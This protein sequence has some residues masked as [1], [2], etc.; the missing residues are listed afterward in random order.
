MYSVPWR[1]LLL[2]SYTMLLLRIGHW[3]RGW[4]S[5]YLSGVEGGLLNA[6]RTVRGAPRASLDFRYLNLFP[7]HSPKVLEIPCFLL[8]TPYFFILK[9]L[10]ERS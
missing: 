7:T 10:Y 8:C 5:I 6:L 2:C 9:P 1:L 4:V 3:Y